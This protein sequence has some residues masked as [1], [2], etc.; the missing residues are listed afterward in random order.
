[1]PA[2]PTRWG[3]DLLVAQPLRHQIEAGR[4]LVGRIPGEDLRHYRRFDRVEPETA[5]VTGAF[6]IQERAIRRHTPRE[7][8]ATPSFGLSTPA[9]PVRD[10]GAFILGDRAADLQEE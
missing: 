6:G 3:R 5:G 1:M 10:Q 7:E 4:R 2:P 9:H 8:M